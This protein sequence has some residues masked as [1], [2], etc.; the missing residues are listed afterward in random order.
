MFRYHFLGHFLAELIEICCG[1]LLNSI[2]KTYRRKCLNLKHYEYVF[3]PKN[4]KCCQH[5][6]VFFKQKISTNLIF[7]N[8][9]NA[10]VRFFI[11]M[12]SICVQLFTA[13]EE[14]ILK[15]YMYLGECPKIEYGRHLHGNQLWEFFFLPYFFTLIIINIQ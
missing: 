13:F 7:N 3:T 12:S 8:T 1:S 15:L 9:K 14:E 2:L 5:F 10:S 4:L 6:C 11:Y